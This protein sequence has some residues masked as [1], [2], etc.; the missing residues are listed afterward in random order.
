MIGEN[1]IR[2]KIGRYLSHE[3]SLDNF[4]DWIVERS[5]NMHMDSGQPAQ[6]LVS[7]VELRLAEYASEH[8][9]ESELRDELRQFVSNFV[10]Y[11]SF[12]DNALAILESPPNNIIVEAKPMVVSFRSRPSTLPPQA[13]SA[14]VD[15]SRA[16]ALA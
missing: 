1:Q 4:E 3:I 13:A 10:S 12:D 14:V 8:L 7:A 5:W 16:V 9:S 6:K 2:E 15:R 11:L